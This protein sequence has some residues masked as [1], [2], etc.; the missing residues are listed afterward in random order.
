MKKLFLILAAFLGLSVQAA[1]APSETWSATSGNLSAAGQALTI[2]TGS[3]AYDSIGIEV[4]GTFTGLVLQ[5]S[6]SGSG[7]SG[8]FI[9]L[10]VTPQNGSSGLVG[11]MTAAG[12]YVGC[13]PAAR[14]AA[15]RVTS[16]S[17]GSA[18]VFIYGRNGGC[19]VAGSQAAAGGSTSSP[20]YVNLNGISGA[21][22]A[23]Y[24]SLTYSVGAYSSTTATTTA[25][26]ARGTGFAYSV[27]FYA[28]TLGKGV[29]DEVSV[30]GLVPNFGNSAANAM[31]FQ[32]CLSGETSANLSATGQTIYQNDPF[33]FRSGRIKVAS[34]QL[35]RVDV[36][37]NSVSNTGQA[38][39]VMK[40][41]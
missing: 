28:N 20:A 9:N 31:N 17:T 41:K 32:L 7:N 29:G 16:I 12:L 5:L 35:V 36:A 23:Y 18:S 22:K 38:R 33:S 13:A 10:S 3:P 21:A 27:T 40:A 25:A 11:T 4:S 8:T 2:T 34:G 37:A 26:F 24:D 30:E 6:T 14:W 39:L 19:A 1:A 15:V